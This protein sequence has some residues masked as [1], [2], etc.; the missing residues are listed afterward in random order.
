[1]YR[2]AAAA[3]IS[4]SSSSVVRRELARGG[5]YGEAEQRRWTRRFAGKEVNFGFDARA[6]IL[7]GVN[8]PA[9]ADAVKVIMGPS[10]PINAGW[11]ALFSDGR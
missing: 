11:S 9:P 5:V 4:W 1:M 8:D 3:A 10:L 2:T 7:R 6:A